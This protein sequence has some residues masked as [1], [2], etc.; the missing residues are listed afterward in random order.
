MRQGSRNVFRKREQKDTRNNVY[1]SSDQNTPSSEEPI[2]ASDPS[3]TPLSTS[4]HTIITAIAREENLGLTLLYEPDDAQTAYVDIV[5]L[6]GLMGNTFSMWY[7]EETKMHWP[8]ML[9]ENDLPEARTFSF[10]YDASVASFWGGASKN[11]L[12]NYAGNMVGDLAGVRG[13]F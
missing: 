5:F 11:R 8:S 10:G 13:D 12:T 7:H 2:V 9:L 4:C 3:G 1:R 6:H